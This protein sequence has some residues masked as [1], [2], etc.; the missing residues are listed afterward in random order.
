MTK[1]E[2]LNSLTGK[3][4]KIGEPQ[5][6]E[7]TFGVATYDVPVF[8]IN[9]DGSALKKTVS[10]Y[11]SDEATAEETASLR[12]VEKEVN[13]FTGEVDALIQ[14]KIADKTI[15]KGIREETNEENQFAIVKA[16]MVVN[17]VVVVKNFFVYNDGTLQI[18]PM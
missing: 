10:F 11:V 7:D 6:V 14:A 1:Q 18:K 13:P 5:K 8:T 16:Y 9:E 15:L 12:Q 4:A 2:L 3:Y 17:N